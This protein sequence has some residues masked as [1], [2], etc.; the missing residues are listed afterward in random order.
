MLEAA[1][2]YIPDKIR[3]KYQWFSFIYKKILDPVSSKS[4]WYKEGCQVDAQTN[5]KIELSKRHKYIIQYNILNQHP[6]QLLVQY[7]KKEQ[8]LKE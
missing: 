1:K 7:S 8:S 2:R 6:K 4:M 3:Q 5:A